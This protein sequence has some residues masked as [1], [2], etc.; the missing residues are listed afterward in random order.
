M[1]ETLW[2]I[3]DETAFNAFIKTGVLRADPNYLIFDG[4]FQSAYDWMTS[5]MNLRIGPAPDGVKY[6]IWAWYQWEGKRKRRDLRLS[7]YAKRGT[8]M[9]QITFEAEENTFLLSD[10]DDWHFVL[11]DNYIPDDE[12]DWDS[13]YD[14][15]FINKKDAI[16]KS[17]DKIFDLNR[18]NSYKDNPS[19]QATLWEIH[20]SQVKKVDHF[21]AK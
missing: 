12:N 3:Q 17:W 19:L 7:G 13:F 11:C 16:I 2:T 14:N 10:F 1:K 21:I 9:V 6:P 4:N 5:Q 15:D 18:C 20:L 8:P